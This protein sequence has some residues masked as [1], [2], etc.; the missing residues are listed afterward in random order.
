M[1]I[2]IFTNKMEKGNNFLEKLVKS[3]PEEDILRY[4][5]SNY[6]SSLKLKNGDIY[7]VVLARRESSRGCKYQKAYVDKDISFDFFYY[8]IL[9]MS[10][11]VDGNEE[12]IFFD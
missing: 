3:I 4:Q 7:R 10:W 8:V 5:K 1:K 9:P 2:L 11:S 12:I 6:G